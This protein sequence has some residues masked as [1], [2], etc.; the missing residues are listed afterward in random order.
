[1]DML[2]LLQLLRE[3]TQAP[4]LLQAVPAMDIM[5]SMTVTMT[6]TMTVTKSL[7]LLPLLLKV[8][9]INLTSAH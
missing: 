5:I 7:L 6:M 2:N 8:V 4:A 9:I 1:M 3:P